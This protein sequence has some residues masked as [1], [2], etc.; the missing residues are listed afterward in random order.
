[1]SLLFDNWSYDFLDIFS[2]ILVIRISINYNVSAIFKTEIK[3]LHKALCKTLVSSLL[4]YMQQTAQYAR[5]FFAPLLLL[6]CDNFVIRSGGDQVYQ[7]IESGEQQEGRQCG[8][9]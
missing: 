6:H 1:M 5:R 8:V 7:N 4:Y 2:H 9:E 3:P